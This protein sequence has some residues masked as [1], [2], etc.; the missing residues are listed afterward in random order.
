[1]PRS[2]NDL[3][4]YVLRLA[5]SPCVLGQR[6]TEW[7]ASAPAIEEDIALAN[8]ALDC[9]GQAR[10]LYAHAAE[11]EDAGR[12]EDDLAF[13]RDAHEFRNYLIVEQPN[14]D[15][16][17]TIMRQLLYSAFMQPYYEALSRS[18]DETL[19]GIAA[20][21]AKEVAYH[22]RHSAEWVI[23]LGDGTGLSHGKAQAALDALWMY[24]G[25]MF[26]HD[27]LDAAMIEA[28][29]G[30][31]A[32]ALKP[33]WDATIDAVLA[34]AT[35]ERPTDGWMISGGRTGTHTEHLGHMLAEMQFLQRA[36]PGAQ[37]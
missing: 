4:D 15:F 23:R 27:D 22:V 25:E 12:S 21:A 5:D 18:R 19:A 26:E 1:M 28:G 13:L 2:D 6:L 9:W 24:T 11:V 30:V 20:K 7:T 31:D 29:I 17:H 14:G 33:R 3:F 34:E 35:L 32:A 10:A 37:W 36:Y 8:I 16:A